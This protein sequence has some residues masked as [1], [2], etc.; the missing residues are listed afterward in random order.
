MCLQSRRPGFK[1]WVGK[2]PWR[3][4]W[5][6]TPVFWPGDFHGLYSPWDCKESD[7]TERL[8]LHW[9]ASNTVSWHKRDANW[10]LVVFFPLVSSSSASASLI[11]YTVLHI[12]QCSG[13]PTHF[14]SS[15]LLLKFYYEDAPIAT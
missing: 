7:T 12:T 10:I 8:S 3:R 6:P 14:I 9:K 13:L 11:S 5:L 2:I 4:E 15:I 1:P